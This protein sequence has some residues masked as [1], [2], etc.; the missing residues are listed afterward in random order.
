MTAQPKLI[1]VPN[2]EAAKAVLGGCTKF[3]G[4]REMAEE[5]ERLRSHR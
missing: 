5:V 3:L 2:E 4:H 1:V